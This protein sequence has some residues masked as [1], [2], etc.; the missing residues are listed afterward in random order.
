MPPDRTMNMYIYSTNIQ[1]RLSDERNHIHY[2]NSNSCA[3]CN[4][5]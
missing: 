1:S 2:C 3:G 5:N 4:R